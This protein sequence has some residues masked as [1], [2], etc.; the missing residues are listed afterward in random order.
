MLAIRIIGRRAEGIIRGTVINGHMKSEWWLGLAHDYKDE[1]VETM[2]RLCD[3]FGDARDVGSR[4]VWVRFGMGM[5]I[6]DV[7]QSARPPLMDLGMLGLSVGDI[8]SAC[9]PITGARA[10]RLHDHYLRSTELS[11]ELAARLAL[12][13]PTLP[14]LREML[15]HSVSEHEHLAR[16]ADEVGNHDAPQSGHDGTAGQGSS[17]T[18]PPWS[19]SFA[20]SVQFGV[21]RPPT[22]PR[23]E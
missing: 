18:K 16:C 7:M 11:E 21:Q 6:A 9:P 8:G 1:T 2:C 13:P 19:R 14:V 15:Q 10:G 22:A 17:S 5:P 23:T 3:T 20:I 4:W 12:V